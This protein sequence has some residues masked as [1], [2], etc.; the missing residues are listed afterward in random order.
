MSDVKTNSTCMWYTE[1]LSETVQ[2]RSWMRI[3]HLS[4]TRSTDSKPLHRIGFSELLKTYML[5]LNFK[6][7]NCSSICYI[8]KKKQLILIHI[9]IRKKVLWSKI[10][11]DIDHTRKLI[12]LNTWLDLIIK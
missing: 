5:M 12:M 1:G 11:V 7:S 8:S 2:V 10:W 3:Q 6:T 4:A 9:I